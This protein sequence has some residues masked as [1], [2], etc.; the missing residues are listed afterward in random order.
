[1]KKCTFTTFFDYKCVNNLLMKLYNLLALYLPTAN[2]NPSG[3][4]S[5]LSGQLSERH[6]GA[7]SRLFEERS[8][9]S[10]QLA[11]RYK[12]SYQQPLRGASSVKPSAGFSRRG[13]L[14]A[15]SKLK[16]M[17]VIKSY[18]ATTK[19]DDHTFGICLWLAAHPST[20]FYSFGILDSS[21]ALE[22]N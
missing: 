3:K 21:L 6:K 18:R 8:A 12:K 10:R 1:M 5:A 15:V 16:A 20:A 19:A 17:A 9:L 2:L 13:Q 22:L 11:E 7:I 4:L 14:S